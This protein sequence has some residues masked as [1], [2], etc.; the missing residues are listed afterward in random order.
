MTK[1]ATLPLDM[2]GGALSLLRWSQKVRRI[3][4]SSFALLGRESTTPIEEGNPIW[5]N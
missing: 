5:S 3:S 2:A 4:H 1:A